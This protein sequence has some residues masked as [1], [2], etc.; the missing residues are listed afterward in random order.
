MNSIILTLYSLQVCNLNFLSI[1][2]AFIFRSFFKQF[3]ENVS[4]TKFED[5]HLSHYS[6]WSCG[7]IGSCINAIDSEPRDVIANSNA[8]LMV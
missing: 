5:D 6:P 4:V 8:V 3:S 2:F 1:A 7:T